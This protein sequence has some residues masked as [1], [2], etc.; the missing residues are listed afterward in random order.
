MNTLLTLYKCPQHGWVQPLYGRTYVSPSEG[1]E[2]NPACPHCLKTLEGD[3]L[4][5]C[6]DDGGNIIDGCG[7]DCHDHRRFAEEVVEVKTDEYYR[8]EVFKAGSSEEI[9]YVLEDGP[10]KIVMER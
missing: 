9:D 1:V 3:A 4:E 7:K 8:I 6:L 2:I 10:V 5:L